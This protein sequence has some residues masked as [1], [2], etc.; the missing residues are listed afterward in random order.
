MNACSEAVEW[1][2]NK[3]LDQAWSECERADWMFWLAGRANIGHKTIVACACDIAETTLK[4]VPEGEPRP[5]EAIRVTSAWLKGEASI[6]EVGEA[7]NAVYVA[8]AYAADAYAYAA[9]A[10][11]VTATASAAYASA[12]ANAAYAAARATNDGADL[13]NIL[14]QHITY[15]MIKNAIEIVNLFNERTQNDD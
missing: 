12:S 14:R 1:V 15:E 2:D 7:A 3:Y 10:A 4:Y 6:E 9:S 11:T 13:T 5:A 8:D